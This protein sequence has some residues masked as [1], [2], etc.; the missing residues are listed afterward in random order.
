MILVK[1]RYTHA[2]EKSAA[3]ANSRSPPLVTMTTTSTCSAESP[4]S[5]W[6]AKLTE[7]VV[8]ACR[9]DLRRLM[10][11][12]THQRQTS[13]QRSGSIWNA[14]YH[15]VQFAIEHFHLGPLASLPAMIKKPT[16]GAGQG[17]S[18]TGALC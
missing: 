4:R 6:C 5:D 10:L 15:S 16:H 17:L 7:P 1:V 14:A 11:R 8:H 3:N 12:L 2:Q 13:D 9:S 18:R